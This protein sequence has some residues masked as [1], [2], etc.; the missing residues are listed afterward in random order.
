MLLDIWVVFSRVWMTLYHGMDI[1]VYGM[2]NEW[3]GY[4]Y[5]VYVM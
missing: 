4:C 2:D 3:Y 5:K 1:I